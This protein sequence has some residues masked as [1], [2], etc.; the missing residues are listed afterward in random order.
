MNNSQK[1]IYEASKITQFKQGCV[2]DIID[3]EAAINSRRRENNRQL[4]LYNR[5]K[6]KIK[7][8][9]VKQ[10]NGEAKWRGN[11]SCKFFCRRNP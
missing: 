8:C 7:I 3:L 1:A 11:V 6:M 4:Q 2:A 5:G 10:R 9:G